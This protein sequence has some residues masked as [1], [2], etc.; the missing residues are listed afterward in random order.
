M[1]TFIKQPAEVIDYTLD[2]SSAVNTGDTLVADPA[3]E[4]TLELQ[5]GSGEAPS[6]GLTTLN[7]QGNSI[8]Q[9]ISGGI[10]GQVCLVTCRVAT[11]AG[12]VLEGEARLK[13]KEIR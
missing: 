10:D 2:F 12:E 4:V 8:K 9:R 11:A 6:L 3:P 5:S 13:I 1:D 7:T